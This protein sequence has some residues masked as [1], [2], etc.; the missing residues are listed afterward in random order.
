MQCPY[1]E[2]H[3]T[4]ELMTKPCSCDN[5][6]DGPYT[7]DQ[8]R[9]C[10]LYKYNAAYKAAWDGDQ[11]KIVLVNKNACGDAVVMTAAIE[12]L[13]QTYP[14]LFLTGVKTSCDAIFEN[15]PHIKKF[16]PDEEVKEIEVNYPDINNC[17]Y[18]PVHFMQA[19]CNDL[20][21]K[22]GIPLECTVRKPSIYLSEE[23]MSYMSRIQ[24]I[25]GKPTRHWLVSCGYK[26]DY[27]VKGLSREIIQ[28]VVTHFHRKGITWVQIGDSRD[29]HHELDN[30]INQIGK[31]SV[32]ELLRLVQTSDFVLCGVTF[33]Y[34]IAG[35]LEKPCVSI[36]GG[37]EPI[38]W[39]QLPTAR[40][41]STEGQLSCC[42]YG[43]CWKN[44]IVQDNGNRKDYELCEKPVIG[45][46]IL[47]KCISIITADKIIGEIENFIYGGII[48]L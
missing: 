11:R 2:A 45:K 30:V 40:L 10:W 43:A 23:E 41:L 18:K 34:W 6:K 21:N 3:G 44:A 7:S 47:P 25:T 26:R 14:E 5:I 33:A 20:S 28:E 13:H 12:S 39:L 35:A 22:L 48:Q 19:Y 42:R 37:R 8:C 36:V 24:E 38:W 46:E 31:T 27:P 1:A 9:L 17:V 16:E 15:N 32:R 4:K 29:V